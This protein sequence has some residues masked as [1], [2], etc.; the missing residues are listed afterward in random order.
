[1]SSALR[2]TLAPVLFCAAASASAAELR[3]VVLPPEGDKVATKLAGSVELNLEDN[4]NIILL[5]KED[6]LDRLDK[7]DPFS[8]ARLK[9]A[10]EAANVDV[11]LRVS[12]ASVKGPILITAYDREGLDVEV[13][14]VPG[15]KSPSDAKTE[16]KKAASKVAK[17]LDKWEAKRAAR[18]KKADEEEK[19]SKKKVVD[20]DATD[21]DEGAEDLPP[22]PPEEEPEPSRSRKPARDTASDEDAGGGR[23]IVGSSEEDELPFPA[24]VRKPARS[25]RA[26]TQQ[27]EQDVEELGPGPDEDEEKPKARKGAR[28]SEKPKKES[29]PARRQRLDDEEEQPPAEEDEE[30]PKPKPSRR[31]ALAEADNDKANAD[32]P[33]MAIVKNLYSLYQPTPY[34]VVS[35]GPDVM[36]WSYALADE[37][38]NRKTSVCAPDPKRITAF[39]GCR[40]HVG[41]SLWFE[42][43]PIRYL[44]MDSSV[45]LAG[46]VYSPVKNA[47]GESL[48]KPEQMAAILTEGHVA[49]KARFVLHIGPVPGI[50]AGARIRLGYSRGAVERQTPFVAIPGYHA[51]QLGFGPEFHLPLLWRRVS[52]D[53]RGE[54]I[55]LVAYQ[56]ISGFPTGPTEIIPDTTLNNP[57]REVVAMGY[58]VDSTV[59]FTIAYGG[60]VEWRTFSEGF[61]AYF[62]GTGR[63]KDA[64]LQ[65]VADGRVTNITVGTTI[66]VGWLFPDFPD[67]KNPHPLSVPWILKQT[68]GKKGGATSGP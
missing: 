36:L 13:V 61:G 65:R 7:Q 53:L 59:R 15:V 49:L 14:E 6:L 25:G 37:A 66:A 3:T 31:G 35:L 16:G 62:T 48:T 50:A 51:A 11:L 46:T 57:G 2:L 44:G 67:P 56:E 64:N 28:T 68:S 29:K 63:R 34:L 9:G 27:T 43:W 5:P 58:R 55:P 18:K 26:G 33:A 42:A 41:G 32:S 23:T 39:R 12:R 21:W 10:M 30:K 22:P 45:R 19:K 4:E 52:F 54:L 60:F 40:P 38:F 47:K 24:E 17:L 20:E 1:M 8:R